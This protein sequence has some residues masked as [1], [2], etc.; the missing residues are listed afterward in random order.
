VYNQPHNFFFINNDFTP[1]DAL[2]YLNYGQIDCNDS[3]EDPAP[4]FSPR[5]EILKGLLSS[6]SD[7]TTLPTPDI[8]VFMGEDDMAIQQKPTRHVDYL[9]H[10][11]N[12]DVIWSS[13][14]HDWRMHH[15]GLG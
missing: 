4:P 12:E 3:S 5:G 1:E 2:S 11:W 10:N 13:W 7:V 14:K 6:T 9:S 15:G 8:N